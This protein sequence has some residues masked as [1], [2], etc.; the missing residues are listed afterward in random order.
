VT[1]RQGAKPEQ[2]GIIVWETDPWKKSHQVYSHT[3][4]VTQLEY[5]HDDAYLCS[6]SRDR[7]LSIFSTGTGASPAPSCYDP[8]LSLDRK[9]TTS[10]MAVCVWCRVQV[11]STS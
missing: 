5:S 4:T 3:L 10:C 1:R 6:A 2:C 8:N 7:T 9:P 11:Q